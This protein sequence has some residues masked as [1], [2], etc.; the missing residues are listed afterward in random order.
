MKFGRL[1]V[2]CGP[3][4]GGKTEYLIRHIEAARRFGLKTQTFKP[5][6]DVRNGSANVVSHSGHTMPALAVEPPELPVD[7]DVGLVAVDEAQFF[8]ESFPK[9]VE[10]LV[11]RGVHVICAGLD[12]TF[13]GHPFH[14]MPAL[15]AMADEV[16]KVT[17]RCSVCGNP[18]TRTQRLGAWEPTDTSNLQPIPILVGGAESYQ[19]RCRECH[20]PGVTK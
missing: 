6:V 7:S 12:L 17:A 19:P 9:V 4:F 11:E 1:V 3:M 8:G 10:A 20:K 5:R 14:P 15:M 2:V 16:V 13:L 18:A